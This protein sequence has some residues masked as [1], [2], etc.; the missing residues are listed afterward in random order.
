MNKLEE[1]IQNYVFDFQ[2]STGRSLAVLDK[3]IRQRIFEEKLFDDLIGK[4]KRIFPDIN[5]YRILEIGSGTG[6][7]SV[8]LSPEQRFLESNL[9]LLGLQPRLREQNGIPIH[10][11]ISA[12]VRQNPFPLETGSLT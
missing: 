6:G 10:L 7:L 1:A 8:A 5:G 3:K 9:R 4:L 2:G 11:P 12:W